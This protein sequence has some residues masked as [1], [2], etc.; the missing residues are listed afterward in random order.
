MRVLIF[1]VTAAVAVAAAQEKHEDPRVLIVTGCVDSTWL[2]VVT[3]DPIKTYTDKFRLRGSK[4]VLK[5]LTKDLNRHKVEVT[6]VLKDPGKTM[7]TGKTVDVGKKTK[8]Y[9]GQRERVDVPAIED[10]ILTVQ[11]YRDIDKTCGR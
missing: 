1:I 2:K 10:P 7:G 11:S 9:V 8:I 4:D 5:V 6:G 3:S